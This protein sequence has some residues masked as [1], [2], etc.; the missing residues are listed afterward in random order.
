MKREDLIILILGLLLLAG[1][2]FT[3]FFGGEKSRHGTG[4]LHDILP[5]NSRTGFLLQ[6]EQS[7]PV[8]PS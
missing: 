8:T 1:M 2:L 3:I 7:A 5:E 4:S 6:A